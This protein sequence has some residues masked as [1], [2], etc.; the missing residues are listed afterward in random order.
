MAYE[1]RIEKVS[2]A[3]PL[4]VVRRMARPAQFSRVV[5]ECCGVVWSALKAAGVK[6]AGRHVAVYWD[7]VVNLEVG[8]EMHESFAGVGEVVASALP[9]G[10]V[11][12]VAHF[13]PYQR[14]GE[15]HGAVK[16]WCDRNVY[17]LA[18]AKWE[19][20]GH[21]LEE[22]NNDPSKIRTEVFYLVKKIGS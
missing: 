13:G 18:G 20:Y 3:R 14:L 16:E 1:V 22:W 19:I 21:W 8:V 15:A 5:P 12:S 9:V 6:G 4:A 17:A 7:E 2:E 10:V 11:A